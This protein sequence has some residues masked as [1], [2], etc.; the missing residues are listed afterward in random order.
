MR[1]VRCIMTK[2]IFFTWVLLLVPMVVSANEN[3][4]VFMSIEVEEVAK[5]SAS[6]SL[7]TNTSDVELS[8]NYYPC[9]NSGAKQSIS[10]EETISKSHYIKLE[11]LNEDETYCF[12]ILDAISG[13]GSDTYQFETVSEDITVEIQE[14]F[15]TWNNIILSK[16]KSVETNLLVPTET[17]YSVTVTVNDDTQVKEIIA[18][19]RGKDVLG[20]S[21]METRRVQQVKLL[22][23]GQ[24][25]FNGQLT[26]PSKP[27]IYEI[28]IEMKDNSNSLTREL[29]N[30]MLFVSKPLHIVNASSL[31]GIAGAEVVIEKRN[32]QT[33]LF[34][35]VQDRLILQNQG[36]ISSK[37]LTDPEGHI[38]MA[39]LPGEYKINASAIGFHSIRNE[40]VVD[41][42]SPSFP[43]IS[44][45][46]NTSG[47]PVL[48]SVQDSFSNTIQFTSTFLKELFFRSETY[49]TTIAINLLIT[50]VLVIL[51]FS[52][53]YIHSLHQ[54]ISQHHAK[55]WKK[56]FVIWVED[57]LEFMFVSGVFLS[58]L[59]FL[60][61]WVL[62]D[63]SRSYQFLLFFT[64]NVLF[65][66]ISRHTVFIHTISQRIFHKHLNYTPLHKIN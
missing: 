56:T 13:Q 66:L 65:W 7:E 50:V 39:L 11:G 59:T 1:R 36:R 46:P 28:L 54:H 23:T 64:I 6:I 57:M 40:F 45:Q 37:L 29:I 2:I 35:P 5:T 14:S 43:S 25:Q 34:E 49:L 18:R 61:Y 51:L 62:V 32:E 30:D 8:L 58:G 17:N 60:M 15:I 31:K 21:T 24:N 44:L 38:N 63:F 33:Q 41:A 9:L 4:R 42:D 22:S 48:G 19:V 53:F 26:T 20:T 16:D 10:F 52:S 27:G 55:Y 12:Q 3:E 47:I